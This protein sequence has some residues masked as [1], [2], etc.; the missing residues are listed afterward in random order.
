[1]G[2]CVN[3]SLRLCVKADDVA[4]ES[5]NEVL[6]NHGTAQ[7]AKEQPKLKTNHSNKNGLEQNQTKVSDNS[8]IRA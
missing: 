8:V 2:I 5:G 1:M 3:N 6:V 7:K 4:D